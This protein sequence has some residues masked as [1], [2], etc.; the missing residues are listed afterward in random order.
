MNQSAIFEWPSPKV[1]A[2]KIPMGSPPTSGV[3]KMIHKNQSFKELLS[4]QP[5]QKGRTKAI[6]PRIEKPQTKASQSL[7][8]AKTL[9]Q[10]TLNAT[11]TNIF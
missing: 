7:F 10:A 1:R 2:L 3:I 9:S 5:V 8:F 6:Q 4:Q 11:K